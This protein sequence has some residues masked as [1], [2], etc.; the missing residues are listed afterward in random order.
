MQLPHDVRHAFRMLRKARAF[1]A[2]AVLTIALGIA[3]NTAVFSV[4][5]AVVLRPLPF[6]E[7]DRLVAVESMDTRGAPH[8]TNLSYPNFF[9]FRAHNRVF[10]HIVCYRDDEFTLTGVNA[11]RH[12]AGEIVSWDMLPMLQVQPEIGRGFLPEDERAGQHVI[13]LSHGLWNEQFGHNL[14][15]VGKTITLDSLPY[16]VVGVAPPGFNFPVRNRQVQVWTT[17]GRDASSSTMTPITEQRGARLVDVT[18]RLKSGVTCEQARAQMDTVAASLAK[19]YPEDNKNTPSTY[20]RPELERMVGDARHALFTLLGAVGL[21]LLIACTNVA[22]L[23]L[24]RTTERQRE[25][26]VRLAIGAGRGRVVRQ[27]LAENLSFALLGCAAG[28]ALASWIVRLVLPLAGDGI[29]RIIETDVDSRVLTFSIGLALLTSLLC[30]IPPA[31]RMARMGPAGSPQAANR[32]C[33]EAHDRFRGGLAVA[34]IALGLV[35]LNGAV[36]LAAAFLYLVHRDLG[37]RPDHLLTF[38]VTLP[39]TRYGDEAQVQWYARLLERLNHLPGVVSAAGGT[40]LPMTG[41]QMSISFDIQ[42]RPAEPSARPRA[43]MAFVT[44]GYFRTIGTP[45]LAGRDFSKRD[46]ENGAPVVIVNEAF[47]REFF[48][49]EGPVGKFIRSGASSMRQGNPMREIVGVVANAKQSPRPTPDSIYYIPYLQLAWGAPSTVVR[50]SLPPLSLESSIRQTVASLDKEVPVYGLRTM[51]EIASTAISPARFLVYLFG[52]FAVLGLLLT[53]VGLYGILSYS[54]LRRSREIGVRMALGANRRM[55]LSMVLARALRIVVAGITLGL[56]GAAAGDRL[57]RQLLF[58]I[59]LS[60]S[61]LI[62]LAC[63]VVVVT[64]A[65]ASYLPARRAASIAPTDA[66]RAE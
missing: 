45:L 62:I 17:L 1:T 43:N 24:A 8:P 44:P 61:L 54:V 50:T 48:P 16:V 30:S 6:P 34:Q 14:G 40:P 55:I 35:L 65:L 37:F 46:D 63:S 21:L 12:L 32:A 5:N 13:I 56:T 52:G 31:L 49:G 53:A 4:V 42:E 9:D 7:P 3:A 51:Q 25:F 11:A 23:L 57:L 60:R 38:D 58:G 41:N 20:V 10:D 36:M 15:I 27:L 29:P 66:L 22:N 18:A 39:A 2:A 33:T 64:A 47:A 59:N 26:A 19:Q 28:V